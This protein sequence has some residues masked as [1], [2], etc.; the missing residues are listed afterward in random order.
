MPIP[1]IIP[2]ALAVAIAVATSQDGGKIDVSKLPVG[3]KNALASGST[4][5]V[6]YYQNA[7][8]AYQ[9]HDE[10]SAKAFLA[11][12]NYFLDKKGFPQEPYPPTQEGAMRVYS[13]RLSGQGLPSTSYQGTDYP[14]G[15]LPSPSPIPMPGPGDLPSSTTS[16][17]GSVNDPEQLY[18]AAYTSYAMGDQASAAAFLA[19]CNLLRM[20]EGKPPMAFPPT[21]YGFQQ[22]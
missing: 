1:L 9:T 4:D 18:Q 2:A 21:Q 10:A 11:S 5:P 20:N 19:K 6:F 7:L 14:P 15:I 8:I 13:L 16:L 17:L 12:C 3:T 22:L